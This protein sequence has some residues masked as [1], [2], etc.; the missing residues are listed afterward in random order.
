MSNSAPR[1]LILEQDATLRSTLPRYAVKGWQGTAVQSMGAALSD[2]VSD[3]ERLRNF[4][5][6]LVGCNFATDGSADSAT[7]RALRAISADPANPAV[8][9]LTTKGS[10]AGRITRV[11]LSKP[12][13]PIVRAARA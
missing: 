9:L 8:I 7:L 1:I 13:D 10:D 2:V 11:H 12:S 6:L 3:S 5:V 4:D